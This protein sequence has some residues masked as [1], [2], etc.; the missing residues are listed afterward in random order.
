M[1][2]KLC[3]QI[4]APLPKDLI[5]FQQ[6]FTVRGVDFAGPSYVKVGTTIKK[7]YIVLFTCATT[8]ATHLELSTDLCTD[9]FLLAFHRFVG[10]QGLPNTISSDNAGTFQAAN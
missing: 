5:Q 3:E 4:E 1:H 6:P 8:R 9:K 2:S 10:R 7:S